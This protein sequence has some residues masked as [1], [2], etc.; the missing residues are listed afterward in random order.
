MRCGCCRD[1]SGL[2]GCRVSLRP[3][4]RSL[5]PWLP[6]CPNALPIRPLC[7]RRRLPLLASNAGSFIC[8][9]FRRISQ[10]LTSG[11]C[12]LLLSFV[13]TL[14]LWNRTLCSCWRTPRLRPH[15]GPNR[16]LWTWLLVVLALVGSTSALLD[17]LPVRPLLATVV[18]ILALLLARIRGSG[19]TLLLRCR[20]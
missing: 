1:C 3:T 17:L 14:C 9:T 2:L 19:L 8:P 13:L 16:R 11:R 7:L 4:W 10:T 15:C 12:W 18:A 6:R 20:L 5:T